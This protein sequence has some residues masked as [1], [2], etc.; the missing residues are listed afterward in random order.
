VGTPAW[1][2]EAFRSFVIARAKNLGIAE[3]TASLARAASLTHSQLSKWFRGQ[4]RPTPA[5][6][7]KLA[8]A[9]ALPGERAEGRTPYTELLVLTGHLQQHEAGMAEPPSPPP[10]VRRDPT[11]V[12]LEQLLSEDSKLSEE[13]Q[14]VLRGLVDRVLAGWRPQR[15]G[16]RRTA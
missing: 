9:I 3:S 2:H 5:S 13:E 12:E 1:D 7:K 11:V 15:N 8:P 16:R 14:D 6:L 10:V 4:E